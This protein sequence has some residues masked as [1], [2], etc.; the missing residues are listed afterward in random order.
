MG[1][2]LRLIHGSDSFGNVCGHKNDAID[3]LPFSGMDMSKRPYDFVFFYLLFIYVNFFLFSY[4]FHLNQRE[5]QNSLKICIHKCPN[6]HLDSLAAISLFYTRTN[7]S[8]CRYDFE[9]TSSAAISSRPSVYQL[10]RYIAD[11]RSM[12]HDRSINRN[13]IANYSSLVINETGLCPVLP[14]YPT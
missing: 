4:L 14:V 5:P 6:E 13:L 10:Q 8:L 3:N 1:S 11:D 9:F 2:P 12:N 7:S